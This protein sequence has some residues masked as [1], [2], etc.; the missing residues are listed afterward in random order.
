MSGKELARFAEGAHVNTDDNVRLE[1]SAPRSLG[2]NTS[3]LN[4][5]LMQPYWIAPSREGFAGEVSQDQHHYY[6]G[7]AYYA[8]GAYDQALQEIDRAIEINPKNAGQFLLRSRTLAMMERTDE[9]FAAAQKALDLD[10]AVNEAELLALSEDFYTRQAEV[11]YRRML[12]NGSRSVR[13]YTGLADIAFHARDLAEAERWLARATVLDDEDPRVLFGRGKLA[14]AR[15]H[16]AEATALFERTRRLGEDSAALFVA[17]A[18]AYGA[19]RQ[20]DK[21][22]SAYESAL[23]RHRRNS[24]WR[25]AWAQA[26]HHAGRYGEAEEKYRELL[27][28]DPA[29]TDAW[30]GLRA[31]RRTF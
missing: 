31:L 14:M 24:G 12:T 29:L 13:P 10:P 22:A 9:A 11:I 25:L 16:V 20:W 19:A 6:I 1:F 30:S 27:A 18:E 21:A 5:G 17:M 4:R 7:Q 15:G 28:L 2:K 3:D 26:L 8:N 23:K